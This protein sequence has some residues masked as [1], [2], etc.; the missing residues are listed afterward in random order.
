MSQLLVDSAT[1]LL[2]YYVNDWGMESL[3]SVT[4]DTGDLAAGTVLGKITASGK[5]V[6]YNDGASNGSEVA[7]GILVNDVDASSEDKLGSMQ[8]FGVVRESRLTGLNANAKTDLAGRF[9]FVA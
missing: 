6:A 9:F 2:P 5:Y 1:P 7:V 4:I 8:V 3:L